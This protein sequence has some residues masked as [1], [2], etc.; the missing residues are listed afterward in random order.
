M[1][2]FNVPERPID[3]PEQ[4]LRK[5]YTCEICNEDIYEGEDCYKIPDY[6]VCCT[7]CIDECKCYSVEPEY[8]DMRDEVM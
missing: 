5:V 4:E 7:H 2:Y 6:G 3:P 8:D 1:N